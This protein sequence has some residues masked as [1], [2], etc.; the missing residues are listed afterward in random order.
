MQRC[1]MSRYPTLKRNATMI[2]RTRVWRTDRKASSYQR[3]SRFDLC[4]IRLIALHLLRCSTCTCYLMLITLWT[5][6]PATTSSPQR[7]TSFQYLTGCCSFWPGWSI[8]SLICR[9]RHKSWE[10][11]G[12]F[13]ED[14]PDTPSP[15]TFA[16]TNS[17]WFDKFRIKC[18]CFLAFIISFIV[19]VYRYILIRGDGQ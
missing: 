15:S 12:L 18:I 5:C 19:L 14:P 11:E 16:F 7:G 1:T 4:Q 17:R 9:F 13:G 10:E 2:S 3:L 6:T 8:I